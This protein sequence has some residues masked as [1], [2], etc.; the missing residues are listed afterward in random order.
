MPHLCMA[1]FLNITMG[2]FVYTVNKN[3]CTFQ[4]FSMTMFYMKENKQQSVTAKKEIYSFFKKREK[5]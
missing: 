1:S 4:W 3:G 5:Q 2:T